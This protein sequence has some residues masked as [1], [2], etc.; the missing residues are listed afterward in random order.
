[1]NPKWR[2]PFHGR[3]LRHILYPN[4]TPNR[5]HIVLRQRL[6]ASAAALPLAVPAAAT[7]EQLATRAIPAGLYRSRLP[8]ASADIEQRGDP[9]LEQSLSKHK[10]T[11]QHT[12]TSTEPAHSNHSAFC[13]ADGSSIHARTQPASAAPAAAAIFGHATTAATAVQCAPP[14]QYLQPPPGHCWQQAPEPHAW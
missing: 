14:G 13:T 2:S 10:H 12:Y 4:F 5:F 11:T 1:M 8:A 9:Q 7:T 3:H 6:R